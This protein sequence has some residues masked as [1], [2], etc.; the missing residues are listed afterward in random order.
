MGILNYGKKMFRKLFRIRQQ[1]RF[2][3]KQ[4]T[5]ITILVKNNSDVIERKKVRL[6]DI[7]LAGAAFSYDI[8]SDKIPEEGIINLS[9]SGNSQIEFEDI[10]DIYFTS[11]NE[12]PLYWTYDNFKRRGIK[13]TKLNEFADE[14]LKNFIQENVIVEI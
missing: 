5:Y 3:A 10:S 11:V 2:K 12:T 4:D 7:S 8:A 14:Y 1:K 6:L 9:A 13:F